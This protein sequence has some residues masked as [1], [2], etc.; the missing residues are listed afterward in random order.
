M[1][2]QDNLASARRALAE[3]S[4]QLDALVVERRERAKLLV[5]RADRMTAAGETL[6]AATQSRIDELRKLL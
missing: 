1:S 2:V 4:S 6:D 5:E 3:L